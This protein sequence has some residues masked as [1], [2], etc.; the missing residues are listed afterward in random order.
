MGVLRRARGVGNKAWD[1]RSALESGRCGKGW[2]FHGSLRTPRMGPEEWKTMR[3]VA[4]IRNLAR[5]VRIPKAGQGPHLFRVGTRIRAV[6]GKHARAHQ[7]V[8]RHHRI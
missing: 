4:Q 6:L 7:R 5:S 3:P 1:G 8:K 2:A